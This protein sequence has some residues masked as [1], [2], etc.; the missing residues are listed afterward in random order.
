MRF[1][2]AALLVIVFLECSTGDP[3]EP[4]YAPNDASA[5]AVDAGPVRARFGLDARPSNRTCHAPERPVQP[6]SAKLEVAFSGVDLPYLTGL[7]QPP[8]D[9]TQWFASR[10]DG[11]LVSFP[12][13][14]TT[15][16]D[17]KVVIDLVTSPTN[18][19]GRGLE[20]GLL[21]F[22]FHPRFA[23]N[24]QVFVSYT[25]KGGP[26]DC[27]SIL[28]RYTS[29]DKGETFGS[30][31][32]ILGPFDQ[33]TVS[34]KGSTVAFD[35]DGKLYVSFGDGGDSLLGQ[36]L[37][38]FFSKVL[39]IDVDAPPSPGLAY[40]IPDDNPF[41]NG[42]GPPE[43]FARGFRN[44]F[45][46]SFD[47]V[48][49]DLWLGDVGNAKWE[50]VDL[51]R[52][53][54]NYG[55][56]CREGAH[57]FAFDAATGC[58]RS[59]GLTDPVIE[60]EHAAPYPSRSVTGGVVYRGNAIPSLVG[61]YVYGDF[62]SQEVFALTFDP[63][64]GSP[65]R[66]LLN[67]DGP[68]GGW[69][70]F[71]EDADGEITI[72]NLYG[73]HF[74]IVPAAAAPVP[75]FPERL[76]KTGCVDASAPTKLAE[77]VIAYSVNAPAFEDGAVVERAFAIPDDA[78]IE[79]RPD[80]DFILPNDSVVLETLSIGGNRIETRLLARS[81]DG[82][83]SGYSYE[84]LDDQSDA[85]LL[86]AN[87]TKRIGDRK[88]TFP[89]RS[90]CVACHNGASA[91][92]VA[93]DV[94]QLNAEFHYASTN[95]I[96][97]QL[98]TFEHVGLIAGPSFGDPRS[99]PAYQAPTSGAPIADRARSWL[100]ANCAHCHRKDNA[101]TPTFDLRYTSAF[102]ET[103]TCNVPAQRDDFGIAG[104][105]LVTPSMPATSVL[106]RR[107]RAP[108]AARMPP[109]ASTRIDEDGAALIEGWIASVGSC[110]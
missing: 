23:D 36:S 100:H 88:W 93:L 16:P 21:S 12:A 98:A 102:A 81:A 60:H 107:L 37:E 11:Y 83:W 8:G 54:G 50:E 48:S 5:D 94:G 101:A 40:A 95:R 39:R 67:P 4:R 77:G 27:N 69:T 64:T 68:F 74:E 99:L 65:V 72:T 38:G 3:A 105:A 90:D 92:T 87:K 86:P 73:E 96:A 52:A 97:N 44:P 57:E 41:K 91:G 46:F 66:T 43:M 25:T 15:P 109:L 61:A 58:P 22:A 24:G 20:G 47:R 26:A 63:T 55:W 85:L 18:P 17:P 78:K 70:S 7:A 31:Q 35:A 6:I 9:K 80:G 42:G 62:K 103:A 2:R 33:P 75:T 10:V 51:V 49:N 84:W 79:R 45:R 53:G 1:D 76:S 13:N 104:A 89:R 106:L 34:H 108:A 14:A 29:T 30:P 82:A 28:V 32:V 19:L 56:P 59:L 71:A 110:P